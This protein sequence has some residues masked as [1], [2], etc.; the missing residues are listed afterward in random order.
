MNNTITCWSCFIG[1]TAVVLL[2]VVFGV[3][4]VVVVSFGAGG[5]TA[6]IG[7]NW[8]RGCA[9]NGELSSSKSSVGKAQERCKIWTLSA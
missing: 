6:G 2:V 7:G 3:V 9:A 4:L 5:I 1:G 8:G